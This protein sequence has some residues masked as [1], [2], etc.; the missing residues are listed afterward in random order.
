M[1]ATPQQAPTTGEHH[2]SPAAARKP[3]FVKRWGLWIAFAAMLA[4][5]VIPLPDTLPVAGHRMLAIFAFAVIVWFTEAV[6]Y[7]VSIGLI[8]SLAAFLL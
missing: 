6:S 7:P 8:I 2:E 5:L 1:A 3:S 4:V